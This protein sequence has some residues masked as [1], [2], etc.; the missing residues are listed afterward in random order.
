MSEDF[1]TDELEMLEDVKSSASK[2][3]FTF[4]EDVKAKKPSKGKPT[5]KSSTKKNTP[6]K[7]SSPK[8]ATPNK[9]APAKTNPEE[10]LM[11]QGL[12]DE[13]NSRIASCVKM[14]TPVFK[15][16]EKLLIELGGLKEKVD[17]LYSL[18]LRAVGGDS[19][20]IADIRQM[21]ASVNMNHRLMSG[22]VA[23]FGRMQDLGDYQLI[24]ED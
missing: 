5:K 11:G 19:E 12:A 2:N 20:A 18:E 14:R 6:K 21:R 9:A 17:R 8:K 4:P 15:E 23:T 10:D 16:V 22:I 7:A 24:T 13:L 3:L 1:D